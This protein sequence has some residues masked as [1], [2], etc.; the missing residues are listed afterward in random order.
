[1]RIYILASLL[2]FIA[3]LG[4]SQRNQYVGIELSPNSVNMTILNIY[5][6]GDGEFYYKIVKDSSINASFIDFTEESIRD[7]A[8]KIDGF[9]NYAI[10]EKNISKENIC[11]AVNSGIPIEAKRKNREEIF[12]YFQKSYKGLSYNL[13]YLDSETESEYAHLSSIIEKF[14]KD[15]AMINI[16]GANTKGGVYVDKNFSLFLPINI[17]WGFNSLKN[18]IPDENNILKYNKNIEK[19]L[20]KIT[21]E[22]KE[23]FDNHKLINY[24]SQCIIGGDLSKAISVIL[25]PNNSDLYQEIKPVQIQA[26]KQQIITNYDNLFFSGNANNL[27]GQKELYRLWEKYDQKTLLVGVNYF[28]KIITL[29]NQSSNSKRFYIARYSSVVACH[30]I[31][32]FFEVFQ[33][34]NFKKD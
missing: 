21:L 10:Q 29:L 30:V 5:S 4:F 26:L 3:L 31:N 28:E 22:I 23:E 9:R 1:M 14:R 18:A 24:Q 7:A 25:F 17:N 33:N 2:N 12:E 20:D 19:S 8:N 27:D 16:D 34:K 11:I 6:K 13:T 32:H 15:A